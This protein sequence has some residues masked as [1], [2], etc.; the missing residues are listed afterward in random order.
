VVQSDGELMP[1]TK[2]PPRSERRSFGRLRQFRSGRWKASYTGP[3][4]KLYEAEH[5]FAA[6]ID[7]EAWLTDRR[8]EI[9]RDLWSPPASP[10]QQKAAKRQRRAAAEQFKPYAE[11]WVKTRMVRGRPLKPRTVEH[12]EKIL[13]DHIYPTFGT[14]PIRDIGIEAVDRW[15][16]KTLPDHPTMRAHAYSLLKT[17][18]E[19]AR[20]RDR[21]IEANPCAIRGAGVTTRT[22]KP[23]PATIEQI[24]VIAGEMPEN[25]KLIVLLASWLALRFG[26]L[27]ELQRRDCDLQDGVI[28]VRRAAVRVEKGWSIGDPKSEAGKRDVA[29]PPHIIPAI[30]DHLAK[31]VAPERNARLFPAKSGGQMVAVKTMID[32]IVS[33]DQSAPYTCSHWY[34]NN[35]DHVYY[36]R[37]YTSGGNVYATNSN[38]YLGYYSVYAYTDVRRTSAGYY[39]YGS[40]P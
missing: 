16:A 37:A 21:L 10:E 40:C 34:D 38:Q 6:K 1:A 19:T 26:E 15:Y 5:T 7:A 32:R 14:K 33:G 25:L 23:K 9:D 30:E 39:A 17:I 11:K 13:K 4:G 22:I 27:V 8:R 18:M 24:N 28:H 29:I 31:H 36:G 35:V 3:D 12:Y 2:K 20:T